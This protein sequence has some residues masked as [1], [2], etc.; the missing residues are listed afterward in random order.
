[1]IV[2][3]FNFIVLLALVVHF[4]YGTIGAIASHYVLATLAY[5]AV[6]LLA[7]I[8]IVLMFVH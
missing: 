1:M 7:L 5:G 6:A 2:F 3:S 8:A 4:G